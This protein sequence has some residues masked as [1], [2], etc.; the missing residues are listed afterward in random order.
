VLVCVIF[1][2]LC[3]WLRI[4][5]RVLH[6]NTCHNFF[7]HI[8]SLVYVAHLFIHLLC[9][10]DSK[11]KMSI[12]N[13]FM[14]YCWFSGWTT[15]IQNKSEYAFINASIRMNYLIVKIQKWQW[16]L[17]CLAMSGK[18]RPHKCHGTELHNSIVDVVI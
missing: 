2:Y 13:T 16:S 14:L 8:N 5:W 15:S 12:F 11:L 4:A 17:Q 18:T 3:N 10:L 9:L 7:P 1:I 6:V